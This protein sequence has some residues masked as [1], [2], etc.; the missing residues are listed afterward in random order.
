MLKVPYR[1]ASKVPTMLTAVGAPAGKPYSPRSAI[2]HSPSLYIK[3]FKMYEY[4]NNQ[5]VSKYKKI[6]FS[7]YLVQK[8]MFG[9]F[10][11]EI[12]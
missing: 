10:L 9:L 12:Y 3:I 7:I 8:A 4:M 11:H 5:K 2:Q 1:Q 6:T